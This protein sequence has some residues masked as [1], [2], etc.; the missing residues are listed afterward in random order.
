MVEPDQQEPYT[1]ELSHDEQLV[2][3]EFLSRCVIDGIWIVKDTAEW[4][5]LS[6]MVKLIRRR[7]SRYLSPSFYC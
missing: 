4:N 1:V 6:E 3:F 2:L 5:V 7:P